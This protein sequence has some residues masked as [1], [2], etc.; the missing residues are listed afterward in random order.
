MPPPKS[1]L[2]LFSKIHTRVYIRSNG[3]R[4]N[5]M[6]NLPV[7]LLTTTG[8]KSGRKHTVPVVYLVEGNGYLIAPGVVPRP[9]WYKNIKHNPYATIQI[10]AQTTP[11]KAEELTDLERTRL[12][13]TVPEYWKAYERRAGITMPLIRLQPTILSL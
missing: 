9:D 1:M 8:R 7:L 6:N 3:R 5:S 11:V 13:D 4:R 10:G 12:W 2:R